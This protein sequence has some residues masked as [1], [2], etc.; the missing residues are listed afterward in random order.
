MGGKIGLESEV[1]LGSTFWFEL[2]LP[3]FQQSRAPRPATNLLRDRHILIVDDNASN[4]DILQRQLKQMEAIPTAASDAQGALA[5]LACPPPGGKW[6]LVILDGQMPGVG[7][8]ELAVQIRAQPELAGLPLVLLSSGGSAT[9]SDSS[10]PV[11]VEAF[12]AKP[13]RPVQLERCL[14]RILAGQKA[15]T[16]VSKSE[17]PSK[18]RSPVGLKILLAEDNFANQLVA[19]KMLAK[20]GHEVEI[21]VNGRMVLDRL[22]NTDFDLV[23]MDCQMPVMDGYEATRQLRQRAQE[24]QKP[25][26]PVI[27]LTAYAMAGDREKCITA[28]MDDYV[29]KPIREIDLKAA[30][31]RSMG[32]KTD[33]PRRVD[34]VLPN[35]LNVEMAQQMME[36]PGQYS[37]SL[38]P[39][40]LTLW[41]EEKKAWD[42]LFPGLLANRNRKELEMRAHRFGGSCAAIGAV[43][44][45]TIALSIERASQ[46]GNWTVVESESSRLSQAESRL[47][48]ALRLTMIEK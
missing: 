33:S 18:S 2:D 6:E 20:L 38:W 19:R 45:Q 34:S 27:A 21:V 12:L 1:G 46:D 32:R 13:V 36:L 17:A 7:G 4:R 47:Q 44:M 40:L 15:S 43:E 31:D 3:C 5:T 42:E 24:L 28:G 41:G 37:P 23:L 22:E 30:L 26:I 10:L 9:Q 39:E 29:I 25:R 35:I 16:E 11:N 48:S 8:L 14:S